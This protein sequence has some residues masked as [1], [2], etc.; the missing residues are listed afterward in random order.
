MRAA[1]QPDWHPGLQGA[2]YLWLLVSPENLRVDF[3]ALGSK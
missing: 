2:H 3:S 1:W